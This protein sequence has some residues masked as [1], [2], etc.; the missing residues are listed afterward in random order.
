MA[1]NVQTTLSHYPLHLDKRPTPKRIGLILLA[2]DHTTERDFARLLNPDEVGVYC[3]RI[4]FENPTSRE[5][6]KKTGP[7]LTEATA[8][9]LPGED[10]DAIV[11]SC[12][13]ASVVLGND[14]V[15]GHIKAA[16]PG[17]TCITPSSA[18]IKA[19]NALNAKR[20]SIMTPYT[21]EVTDELVSYFIANGLDII[22]STCLGMQDDRDMARLSH[23]SIIE[24][25]VAAMDPTADA[26]FISCTALRGAECVS[27]I[28]DKIG[29]PVITSNQA[30]IW[31]TLQHLRLKPKIEG[32]GSIFELLGS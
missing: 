12:T 23:A 21:A 15:E 18:A 1:D 8:K 31:S 30:M 7:R 22:S 24:T 9:I 4:A 2:T 19:F 10:L 32:A 26:L 6:L 5:N 16:K 28:E 3:T 17:A 11:Y 27:R 25:A 14:V 20:I 29:K 13:S